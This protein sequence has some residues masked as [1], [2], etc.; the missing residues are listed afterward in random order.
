MDQA[1]SPPVWHGT[2]LLV[3]IAHAEPNV[4]YFTSG[5]GTPIQSSPEELLREDGHTFWRFKLNIPLAEEEQEIEYRISLSRDNVEG[6]WL[7]NEDPFKFWVPAQEETMRL[8]F[9]TCNGYSLSTKKNGTAGGVLW[10]DVLRSEKSLLSLPLITNRRHSSSQRQT[11]SCSDW[12]W[13]SGLSF[14]TFPSHSV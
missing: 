7:E 14:F 6:P 12:R 10:E 5:N 9:Q 1:S 3:T 8:V 13:G 4:G 2:I 11:F